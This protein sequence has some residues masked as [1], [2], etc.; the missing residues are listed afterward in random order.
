M[1]RGGVCAPVLTVRCPSV[2]VVVCA[3]VCVSGDDG[4][5]AARGW[6]G[7]QTRGRHMQH[8]GAAGLPASG[9]Q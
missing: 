9:G 3:S 5:R 2:R 8:G 4:R 6:W 1:E 7:A